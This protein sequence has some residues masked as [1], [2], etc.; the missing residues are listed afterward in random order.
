MREFYEHSYANVHRGVYTLAERATA[1]YEGAREKVRAYVNAPSS[2]EVIFTRSATE[3]LNLVAYAWGLENL[4]PGDVVVDHR[5]RAPRELRPVA[6]HRQEDGR[7]VRAHPDRRPRRAAARRAR[8]D[9]VARQREGRREQPRLEHARHDQPGR[10]ARR[11]G[12]TSRA[13]SWS[14]TQRRPPRTSDRRAGARLRLPRVLVAQAVRPERHRRALGQARAARADAAVQLRRR[15]DPLGLARATRPGTSCRT[16]SRRE[17]RAIAEAYGFGVALDYVSEVGLD[18]IEAYE[19]ELVAQTIDALAEID[20]IR[21]FGPP[22]DQR[23]GIVSF[24]AR[25]R[26]PARRRADPQLGERRRPRGPPLHPAADDAAR[27]RR[28]DPRELLPLLGSRGRRSPRRGPA[29]GQ[30]DVRCLG[31]TRCTAR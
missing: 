23:T 31:S 29:Q 9:R 1:G 24:D 17:R 19:H 26:P 6:V 16:S 3:A 15:H 5:A 28:D 7:R 4:G 22:A 12:R 13:R 27:R 11:P 14:S 18:T 2:R 21:I 30:G 20:G 10:E 25:G 8:R